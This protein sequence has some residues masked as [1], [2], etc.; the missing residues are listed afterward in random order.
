MQATTVISAPG[1]PLPPSL[2]PDLLAG[3][4]L[5]SH[6]ALRTCAYAA[7]GGWLCWGWTTGAVT[8][9]SPITSLLW[10]MTAFTAVDC[11]L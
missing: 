7:K 5:P 11:S 6:A 4:R 10:P 8:V 3:V 1:P 2:M 9:G